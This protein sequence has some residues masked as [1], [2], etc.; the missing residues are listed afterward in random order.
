MNTVYRYLD[1][2]CK[3]E[4]GEEIKIYSEDYDEYIDEIKISTCVRNSQ[5]ERGWIGDLTYSTMRAYDTQ[6]GHEIESV[7]QST[8]HD[9]LLASVTVYNTDDGHITWQYRFLKK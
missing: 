7:A 3:S 2:V 5:L 9:V 4:S 1:V 6:S 8:Y